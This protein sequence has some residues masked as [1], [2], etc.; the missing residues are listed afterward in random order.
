MRKLFVILV[1]LCA[2]T[3]CKNQSVQYEPMTAKQE[4]PK[5]DEAKTDDA[6][7]AEAPKA[8][9]AKKEEAPKVEE[10]KADEIKPVEVPNPANEAKPADAPKAETAPADAP[11]AEEVKVEK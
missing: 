4:A 3:A 6:K 8:D 9:E 2:L 7:K 5:A 11:K 10:K 1:A